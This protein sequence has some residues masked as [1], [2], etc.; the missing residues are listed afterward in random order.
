MR[1]IAGLSNRKPLKKPAA[2]VRKAPPKLK[3]AAKQKQRSAP[4]LY[5]NDLFGFI[6]PHIG[7]PS[8]KVWS[9]HFPAHMG[10]GT[11]TR[12]RRSMR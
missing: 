7:A 9:R 3:K 5:A 11:G 2:K 1:R 10:R 6:F 8:L 4:Q 12:T